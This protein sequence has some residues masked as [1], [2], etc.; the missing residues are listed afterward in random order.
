MFKEAIRC[1]LGCVIIWHSYHQWFKDPL[2]SCNQRSI[3]WYYSSMSSKCK[4]LQRVAAV[5]VTLLANSRKQTMIL[6]KE[7]LISSA[8]S[9]HKIV[10]DRRSTHNFMHTSAAEI[11]GLHFPHVI[12]SHFSWYFSF[13]PYFVSEAGQHQYSQGRDE[14]QRHCWGH[15]GHTPTQIYKMPRHVV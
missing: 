6:F 4:R 13:I 15:Q 8:I 14:L 12:F 2:P 11:Y 10:S 1:F 3:S 9:M 5:F 7:C